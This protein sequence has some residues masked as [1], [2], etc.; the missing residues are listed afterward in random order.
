MYRGRTYDEQ[1]REAVRVKGED[2]LLLSKAVSYS[3][4]PCAV[5][6]DFCLGRAA[7]WLLTPGPVS[8]WILAKITEK[9]N[10]NFNFKCFLFFG[11]LFVCLFVF[12][13]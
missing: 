9:R 13:R 10:L 4:T 5:D 6:S 11:F 8:P 1:D 3:S 2:A 7:Q 12:S